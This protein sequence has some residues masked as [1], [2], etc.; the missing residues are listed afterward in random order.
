MLVDLLE[1]GGFCSETRVVK[2]TF[3]TIQEGSGKKRYG[4]NCNADVVV[5]AFIVVMYLQPC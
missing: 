4:R 2:G 1:L 3:G 5:K